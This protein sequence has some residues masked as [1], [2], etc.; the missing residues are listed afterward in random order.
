MFVQLEIGTVQFT[1][2][3][4]SIF[5]H[6]N[7]KIVVTCIQYLFVFLSL[8]HVEF[9][10]PEQLWKILAEGGTQALCNG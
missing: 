6:F 1:S 4:T 7:Q 10:N 8:R 5:W 3:N 2:S 9:W